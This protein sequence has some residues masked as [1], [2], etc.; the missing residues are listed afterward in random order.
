MNQIWLTNLGFRSLPCFVE[1]RT[2]VKRWTVEVKR[3]CNICV[4]RVLHPVQP[5]VVW[6]IKWRLKFDE[7]I[8]K[9]K[10]YHWC[11]KLHWC[12][13]WYVKSPEALSRTLRSRFDNSCC[14]Q[15]HT[16]ARDGRL[17]CLEANCTWSPWGPRSAFSWNS[18]CR[19]GRESS[20]TALHS[21]IESSGWISRYQRQPSSLCTYSK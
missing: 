5:D 20:T 3:H 15:C 18:D 14:C 13:L 21:S 7:S 9:A 16:L 6:A 19:Y 1:N 10:T 17:S 2:T 12:A 4:T 11:S 8:K